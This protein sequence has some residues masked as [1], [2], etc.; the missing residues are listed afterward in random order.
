M[1]GSQLFKKYVKF[2][3]DLKQRN[4][5]RAKEILN[6]LWGN[7]TRKQIIK[8]IYHEDDNVEVFPG[9]EILE[10]TPY[11]DE[12]ISVTFVNTNGLYKF[13]WARIGPFLLAK[14]RSM[15][16]KL[17]APHIDYIMRTHTDDMWSSKKLDIPT[18]DDLGKVKFKG[19]CPNAKIVNNGNITG[20]FII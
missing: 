13:D 15:I 3:F 16:S 12:Q 2:L 1:T 7:L 6:C 9:N 14:G 17:I 8:K 11:G 20:K 18:G 10:C 4:I 5:P 19:Y